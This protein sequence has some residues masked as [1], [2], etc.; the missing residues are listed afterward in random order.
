[1]KNIAADQNIPMAFFSLE[2]SGEQLSNRLISNVCEIEG[3]KILSGQL[4][5]TEWE[6]FDKRIN[7]LMEAPLYIDDTPGLSIFELKTKAHRIT[8]PSMCL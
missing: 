3:R 1:M 4:D 8:T 2:M 7:N 6:R 5:R